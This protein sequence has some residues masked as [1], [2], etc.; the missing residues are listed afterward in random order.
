MNNKLTRFIHPLVAAGLLVLAAGTASAATVGDTQYKL[1]KPAQ[2]TEVAPGKVEV[3]EVFWYACPHC[4]A[5]Q[6]KVEAW[7]KKGMP[8]NVQYVWVP[9]TWNELLKTHARIFYTVE[10]LGKPQLHDDVFR[11]INVKG[12]RLETPEKIE[13]FFVTHGVSKADF[14]KAFSSF[15]V[16]SKIRH[17]EDLNRR[18]KITGT[19]TW[20]VAGKYVTE[21]SMAGSEDALFQV[22]NGLVAME[23]PAG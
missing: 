14:Q 5:V 19:P 16:E 10:L 3:V 22:L 13:A 6:P 17:A 4:Y 11:E 7:I 15:A 12:N 20:V 21:V 2:P 18:Y 1:L 9:A 8:A 23:K